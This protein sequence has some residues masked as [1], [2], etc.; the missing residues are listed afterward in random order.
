MFFILRLLFL[1]RPRRPN[2]SNIQ[3]VGR[4][5]AG[6]FHYYIFGARLQ[7]IEYN[8]FGRETI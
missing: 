3:L 2:R 5:T 7:V 1:T 8:Q 4:G 6:V